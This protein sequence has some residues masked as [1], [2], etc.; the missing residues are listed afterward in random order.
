M[1]DSLGAGFDSIRAAIMSPVNMDAN[2]YSRIDEALTDMTSDP[3]DTETGSSEQSTSPET[4]PR[5]EMTGVVGSFPPS[6]AHFLDNFLEFSYTD[7]M[8]VTF[9]EAGLE[10][11]ATD[12]EMSDDPQT[13]HQFHAV[14]TQENSVSENAP[15]LYP[16]PQ[17]SQRPTHFAL[18][19]DIGTDYDAELIEEYDSPLQPSQPSN[20][21]AD[22]YDPD[23][24]ADFYLGDG[25]QDL[26]MH[27]RY[28]HTVT[29]E[30]DSP[31][32][33]DD[34]AHEQPRRLIY[35]PLA[36]TAS[37]HEGAFGSENDPRDPH[38]DTP[39]HG[40]STC[41]FHPD[42]HR[43]VKVNVDLAN[44]MFLL[45]AFERN[46]T[47]EQFIREWSVR[48]RVRSPR[49]PLRVFLPPSV[50][51]LPDIALWT[52]PSCITRPEDCYEPFYDI[53]QIPW[54][55]R[56]RVDRRDARALRDSW[57]TSYHNLKYTNRKVSDCP[58]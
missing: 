17:A 32:R 30:F 37:R 24:T 6:H 25:L 43:K 41:I 39:I 48:S 55:E 54:R 9:E 33:Q 57:Y 58:I 47:I 10:W 12:T 28:D 53:Q 21:F 50:F 36:S 2:N 22:D 27:D 11:Y 20:E 40:S 14:T 35:D 56:L 31:S 34:D 38:L 13:S 16:F 5:P 44:L 4:E 46:L 3:Q 51:D 29:R 42:M 52:R 15:Q 18:T 7:D 26:G 19:E 45:T 23:G 1:D 8:Q 49:D